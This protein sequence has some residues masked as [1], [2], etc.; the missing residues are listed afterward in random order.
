[1]IV[2]LAAVSFADI[3]QYQSA[4]NDLQYIDNSGKVTRKSY[5]IVADRFSKIYESDPNGKL[6]DDS[7]HYTAQT[8]YRSYNRFKHRSD[9]L[10]ALKNLKLLASNY[11][12]RLASLAYLQSAKIYEEQKDYPSARYMLKKLITRFPNTEDSKTAQDKLAQ[13]EK[14]FERSLYTDTPEPSETAETAMEKPPVPVAPVV[15]P[16][17]N[18]EAEAETAADTVKTSREVSYGTDSPLR[19]RQGKLLCTGSDIFPQMT[20]QELS[21]IFQEERTLKST[22]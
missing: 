8:Y 2:L 18:E 4:K 10:S 7:L 16:D 11:Q 13:I 14:K 22:G 9:L 15:V 6:A 17:V 1:M 21:L 12:T 5:L 20:I 3:E 19:L